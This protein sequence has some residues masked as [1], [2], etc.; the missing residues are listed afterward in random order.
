MLGPLLALVSGAAAAPQ[1]LL[2]APDGDPLPGATVRLLLVTWDD[3]DGGH[4]A[5]VLPS[6]E[7]GA[8]EVVEVAPTQRSGVWEVTWRAPDQGTE[9]ELRVGLEGRDPL[10]LGLALGTPRSSAL[11]T[12]PLVKGKAAGGAP[13]QLVVEGADLPGPEDL[14]VHVPEGEVQGI[15]ATDEGLVVRWTPASVREARVVVLGLSDARKG[16]VP[17][18]WISARLRAR[19]PV[20]V[21][22]D[23]GTSLSVRLGGRTY[24]P[25]IADEGGRASTT[26]D[27]WPGEQ[28]AE[29]TLS[30]DLGNVQ[31][32]PILL[33]GS[34][35][36]VL[37]A[38]SGGELIA[39]APSPVVY[40]R[41]VDP[42]GKAWDGAA[43]ECRGTGVGSLPVR[44]TGEGTWEAGLPPRLDDLVQGLRVDC[45]I[46]GTAARW[47]LR[48]PTGAGVPDRVVL[49][50]YP[51]ELTGDFPVA[52]VQAHLEDV[53]G[54]RLAPNA[55]IL[56][57]D[58]GEL[59]ETPSEGLR[60]TADYTASLGEPEDRIVARWHHPPGSGALW[61]LQVAQGPTGGLLVRAVDRRRQP[62]VGV[63]VSATV[64]DQVL[65]GATGLRGWAQLGWQAPTAPAVVTVT[66][67]SQVRRAIV[68]PW[69]GLPVWDP[70]GADLR[71]EQPVRIQ[72]GR[73][74]EVYIDA[75]P[76]VLDTGQGNT[77]R[78]TVRMLDRSG[79]PVR[80]E[81]VEVEADRGEITRVRTLPDGT[82]E[83]TYAPPQG[84]ATGRVEVRAHG[85]D[86][87]FAATTSLVLRPHPVRHSLSVVAGVL[88]GPG[89]RWSPLVAL[90][91]ETH[92]PLVERGLYVRASAAGWLDRTTVP[93]PDRGS[94]VDLRMEMLSLSVSVLG[95]W[96]RDLWTVWAGGG[97]QI[98]PYRLEIRYPGVTAVSGLGLH[99][100]GLVAFAGGGRRFRA[101]EVFAELR[102]LGVSAY[103]DDFGYEGQ[104]GGLAATVGFR[105]IF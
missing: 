46:P 103:T 78:V 63:E 16:D 38:V 34:K 10:P 85:E 100:P 41:A 26:V 12:E 99:Q 40:L 3:A 59:Q 23:P 20:A 11:E 79:K 87:S 73:V 58:H 74:R 18:V 72:S 71:A 91:Y 66:A 48:V 76:A 62:L 54:E 50:V 60:V 53:T 44:G 69:A 27:L 86:G 93:D 47:T 22:T 6:V 95:R 7:A 98:V 36:P 21:T 37:L 105:L 43:P 80:D 96:E 55:L 89:P 56:E 75:E 32:T 8:G 61:D 97:P 83:A 49:R 42:R 2:T 51:E 9:A 67:G 4:L 35:E 13:L 25:V 77:A 104:L 64:G 1:A 70:E 94:E 28:R 15:E 14:V 24:G 29:A 31:R 92:F 39:G 81:A 90:D 30:D 82:L 65:Q 52:Q 17:P 33:P 19:V 84:L 101:G 57:A 5:D 45:A 102:G 68:T 88:A